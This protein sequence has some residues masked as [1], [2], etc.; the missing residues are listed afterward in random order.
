M[1]DAVPDEAR[2]L[3]ATPKGTYAEDATE[4]ATRLLDQ[5][6]AATIVHHLD[7]SFTVVYSA[8]K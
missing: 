1:F 3:L 4:R 2:K 8:K 6:A 7:K 5:S